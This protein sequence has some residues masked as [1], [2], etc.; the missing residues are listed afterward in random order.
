M[1]QKLGMMLTQNNGV[2]SGARCWILV[3]DSLFILFVFHHFINAI[4]STNHWLSKSLLSSTCSFRMVLQCSKIKLLCY[5]ELFLQESDE[6]Q[7]R[8]CRHFYVFQTII[9]QIW[10]L[11]PSTM[12]NICTCAVAASPFWTLSYIW[13]YQNTL[14]IRKISKFTLLLL[15]NSS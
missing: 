11:I 14:R 7:F 10:L 12:Q 8:N 15:S 3:F 2:L 5:W 1:I 13:L 4:L 6:W 9:T